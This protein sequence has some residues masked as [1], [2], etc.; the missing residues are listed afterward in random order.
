MLNLDVNQFPIRAVSE[1]LSEPQPHFH[2][3]YTTKTLWLWD[4][5]AIYGR[6]RT[7]TA[8]L[9]DVNPRELGLRP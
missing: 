8:D 1:M 3:P 7:R 4:Q 2:I 9:M 6:G 5:S